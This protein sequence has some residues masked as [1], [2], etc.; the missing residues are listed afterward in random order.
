MGIMMKIREN[1]P[2]MAVDGLGCHICHDSLQYEFN[3]KDLE[4]AGLTSK[5]DLK[6]KIIEELE[7][8]GVPAAEVKQTEVIAEKESPEYD[9]KKKQKK[10]D[11]K[12]KLASNEL[13]HP[14]DEIKVVTKAQKAAKPEKQQDENE[15]GEEDEEEEEEYEEEEE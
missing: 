13:L 4:E 7:E 14:G 12:I 15:E 2:H 9:I 10:G 1:L 5:K 3:E 8:K 6:E 11:T